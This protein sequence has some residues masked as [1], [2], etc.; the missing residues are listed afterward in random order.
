MLM[1]QHRIRV[2]QTYLAQH[3]NYRP[4]QLNFSVG[5]KN[6]NLK[7]NH[8]KSY[9]LLNNKKPEIVSV[10]SIDG[11]H[12]AASSNKKLV[13]VK[14]DSELKFENHITKFCLIISKN[15]TLSVVYQTSC[16]Q[17][18]RSLLKTFIESPCYS[19]SLTWMLQSWT[20]NDKINQIRGRALAA[21]YYDYK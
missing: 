11:I 20:L 4:L 3:Q 18:C 21:V 12:V 1:T 2:H 5:L 10:V 16:Q 13:G 14:V 7:S 19:C 6:N 9:I 15:L 8:G 17:K